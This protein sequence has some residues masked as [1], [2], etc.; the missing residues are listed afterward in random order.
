MVLKLLS[1]NKT[2]TH[3]PQPPEQHPLTDWGETDDDFH[4]SA[5][6]KYPKRTEVSNVIPPHKDNRY[7]KHAHT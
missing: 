2:K 1:I 3:K 4:L 6:Q 5:A 7:I